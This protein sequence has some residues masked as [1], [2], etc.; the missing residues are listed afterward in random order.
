M[1]KFA[2]GLRNKIIPCLGSFLHIFAP[3]GHGILVFL[4]LSSLAIIV[5]SGT[6]NGVKSDLVHA[7]CHAWFHTAGA[8]PQCNFTVSVVQQDLPSTEC[9]GHQLINSRDAEEYPA[10]F[11]RMRMTLS[12]YPAGC[13][14][15]FTRIK[16][17]KIQHSGTFLYNLINTMAARL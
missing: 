16:P 13:K 12:H 6:C 4:L 11:F 8:R 3:H 2:V 7:S 10:S 1:A 5:I 15:M 9:S 14:M 17:C